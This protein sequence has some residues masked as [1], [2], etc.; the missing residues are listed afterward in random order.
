MDK[1]IVAGF[2]ALFALCIFSIGLIFSVQSFAPAM[3]SDI[4]DSDS[5]KYH[6]SVCT[7]VV[8]ADGTYEPNGCSSNTLTT[9]GKNLIK[10]A[11]AF[12][13]TVGNVTYIGLCNASGP[14]CNASSADNTILD[15][16]YAAGGLSRG[17]GNYASQGTGNWS[18][19]KTFTAT[20]NNLLT[21]KTGLFNNSAADT[22]FAENTFTLVT[23]QTNDQLTINWTIW[24][25]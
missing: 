21:N 17:G 4:S 14:G 23:L 22:L 5:I 8:R 6:S 11:L 18:V 13:G 15:D 16:E 24:V 7:A 10:N 1:K 20:A 2:L 12:G 19:Y 9:A 25:S 3:G